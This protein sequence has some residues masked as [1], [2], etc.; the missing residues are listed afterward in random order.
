MTEQKI[1]RLW[2]EGYSVDQ[3][4]DMSEIVQKLKKFKVDD[5]VRNLVQH[6]IEKTI[7]KYYKEQK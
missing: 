3:I 6:R 4:T 5:T 7:L 1:I 2:R